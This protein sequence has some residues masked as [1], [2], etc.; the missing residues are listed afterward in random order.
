MWAALLAAAY[1]AIGKVA[2]DALYRQWKRDGL[3]PSDAAYESQAANDDLDA[4]IHDKADSIANT[5]HDRLDSILTDALA[6]GSTAALLDALHATYDQ[7]TGS[8]DTGGS[9]SDVIGT[10][11]GNGAWG[12]GQQDAVT[13]AS[14]AYGVTGTQTWNAVMDARTRPEH[15]DANGQTVPLGE[16]FSVGGEDLDYPGSGGD[17]GNNINC[18][19]F[20]T[21]DGVPV[22]AED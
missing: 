18:R 14:D 19:C 20:I 9:R 8:D 6:A 2:G 4:L 1:A 12:M 7:W 11:E 3:L 10:T 22:G 15:A 16:T 13:T 5:T 21:Y 17:A